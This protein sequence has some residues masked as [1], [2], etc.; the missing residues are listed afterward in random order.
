MLSAVAGEPT[1]DGII[2]DVATFIQQFNTLNKPVQ[3]K[4]STQHHFAALENKRL[5]II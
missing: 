4:V 2:S 3:L 1:H 5:P